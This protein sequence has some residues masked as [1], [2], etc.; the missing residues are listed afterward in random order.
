MLALFKLVPLWVWFAL[1]LVVSVALNL[2]Q[3][4]AGREAAVEHRNAVNIARLEATVDVYADQLDMTASVATQARLDG[5]ALIE[6]LRSI[7]DQQAEVVRRY[8]GFIRELPP[9]PENCGPG[10]QRVDAFNRAFGA[11][12]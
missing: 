1:A 9:L 4:A 8:R 7:S 5:L 10:Q 12:P 3:Y 11:Q 2:H 6:N